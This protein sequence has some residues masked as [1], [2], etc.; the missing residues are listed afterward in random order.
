MSKNLI[1]I[2]DIEKDEEFMMVKSVY[3][4]NPLYNEDDNLEIVEEGSDII[5]PPQGVTK[6]VEDM[7]LTQL[8]EMAKQKQIPGYT[9]MDKDQLLA[10]IAKED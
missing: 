3:E 1:K 2:R 4:G 9:T 10:A 5:E 7:N 6:P 8:R